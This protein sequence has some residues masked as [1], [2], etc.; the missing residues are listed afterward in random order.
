LP[1]GTDAL[2]DYCLRKPENALDRRGKLAWVDDEAV[3]QFGKVRGQSLQRVVETAGDYLKWILSSDFDDD[4][5]AI[6]ND[7]LEGNFPTKG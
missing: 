5:K 2:Q 4:L 1:K 6:I 3:F 7:A